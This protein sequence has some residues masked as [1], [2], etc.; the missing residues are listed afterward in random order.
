MSWRGEGPE[1]GGRGVLFLND[2]PTGLLSYGC[3]RLG[4]ECGQSG[5][6]AGIAN[7]VL[8]FGDRS[9][10]RDLTERLGDALASMEAAATSHRIRTGF[11]PCDCAITM[12]REGQ[13]VQANPASTTS[14]C[15][16]EPQ[17]C[18]RRQKGGHA[19]VDDY[20]QTV[21][22]HPYLEPGRSLFAGDPLAAQSEP[23]ADSPQYPS[24]PSLG[25]DLAQ[26]ACAEG[27]DREPAEKSLPGEEGRQEQDEGQEA[28]DH[29]DCADRQLQ[30]NV[31]GHAR[32][33]GGGVWCGCQQGALRG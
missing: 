17:K 32:A 27:Q 5:G 33:G 14:N 12:Q 31:E 23:G 22:R 6:D 1:R 13:W 19:Q 9:R 3:P 8:G 21:R 25:N 10:R 2:R 15:C 20:E 4:L 11:A 30:A 18:G 7:A 24:P 28:A 16:S 26:E 29:D